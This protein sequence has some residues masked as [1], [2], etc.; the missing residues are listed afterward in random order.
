MNGG[1]VAFD[2]VDAALARLDGV[3]LGRAAYGDPSLL[4]D[5]D[6][7][8]FGMAS[9]P[10]SRFEAVEA[11]MPYLAARLAEGVPL[12]AMTRHMLGLFNGWPGARAWRRH[13]ATEGVKPGAGLAVLRDALRH[14]REPQTREAA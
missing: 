8:L 13:L 2:Q 12:H 11:Y 10:R 7:R 6:G 4:L 1:L 9:P 14:V 3:M 5:V